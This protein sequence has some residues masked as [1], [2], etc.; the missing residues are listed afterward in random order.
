MNRWLLLLVLV[1][2]VVSLSVGPA[3]WPWRLGD[4]VGWAI[5]W[6]LRVPRATLGLLIGG[7][8]GLSGAV[9]QGW[10]RNPLAEPGVIG[11][12]SCASFAAVCAFYSGLAAAFTLALPLAGIAGAAIAVALLMTAVRAGT[13]TVSLLLMGVAINAIAAALIALVL[14]SS[15][16]PFAYQE[17]SLWLA[18]SI[19]D[20]DLRYVAIS[21]PFMIVGAAIVLGAGRWL[22]ALSLGEETARSLGAETGRARPAVHPG[23]RPHGRCRDIGRGR[24]RL[25]RPG[26]AASRAGEGRLQAGCDHGA[27]DAGR[28]RARAG[29]RHPGAAAADCLRTAARRLHLACRCAFPGASYPSLTRGVACGMSRLAARALT[30]RRGARPVLEAVDIAFAAGEVTAIVGPNGSGKT[31]LLHHL[32]GLDVAAAGQVELDGTPLTS[33]GTAVRARRIAYLPQGASVYWP[34]LGRDLVALGRLPH[35]VDL[36]RP[37]S[38]RDADAVRRALA[39]VD[40]MAFADRP[41]DALSQGERARLLLARTLATEADIL[42]A[43]EPVASLDPAYALDAMTVLRGE[44]QRGACVVVSLHDLGLAARFADRVIVLA[45]G[46]IA[47]DGPAEIALRAEVIDAAYGVG[48]RNIMIDGI[49]QPVA[50]SR[51]P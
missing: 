17:I 25:R 9:L 7:V 21:A 11:V 13:G 33:L 16:N 26:G 28:G 24:H 23:S 29:S 40:G 15:P 12:S 30:C 19:V 18:G 38:S 36:S 2:Y 34:L 39:R 22:D 31:T 6:Q 49:V 32:A 50:W 43:D 47:A 10:L 44:A 8:L 4:E 5:V 35:G 51:Q 45:D 41:I 48:F 27:L 14:A 42:L 37:I 20:R 1:L 46:K 3:L